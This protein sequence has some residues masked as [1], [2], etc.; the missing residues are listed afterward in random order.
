[1]ASSYTLIFL[2]PD[3]VLTVIEAVIGGK[4]D[5]GVTEHAG[6]KRFIYNALDQIVHGEE[7]GKPSPV[8]SCDLIHVGSAERLGARSPILRT[9][10]LP[11]A[12]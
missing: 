6:S 9:T 3:A 2:L 7:S 12:V 4:D 5:Y 10:T 8:T 11:E 1:V